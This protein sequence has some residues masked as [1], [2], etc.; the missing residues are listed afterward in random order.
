MALGPRGARCHHPPRRPCAI[1]ASAPQLKR[2]R[3]M[4]LS[5]LE[6]AQRQLDVAASLFVSDGDYLAVVTLAGA[7]EEILGNLLRRA[8]HETMFDHLVELD[9][10]LTG[11]RTQK[12][13]NDEVN[14]VRNALKHANFPSEDTVVIEPGEAT[15][16]LGRAL[17]NFNRF[18]GGLTPIMQ[19]AV[20]KLVREVSDVAR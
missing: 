13:V 12:V 20:D 8:G 17:V 16:M 2:Q 7:A 15:A 19:R 1:P 10:E 6:I 3:A 9:R 11:G 5:K 14:R 18:T 4:E